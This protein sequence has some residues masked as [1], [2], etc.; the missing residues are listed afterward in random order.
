MNSSAS[1]IFG[2]GGKFPAFNLGYKQYQI[3]LAVLLMKKI[4]TSSHIGFKL[5]IHELDLY[6]AVGYCNK[7]SDIKV[8]SLCNF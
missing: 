2:F 1:G 7:K 8:I 4:K 6:Y 5:L 3:S